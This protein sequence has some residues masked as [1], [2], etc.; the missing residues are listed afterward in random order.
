MAVNDIG[1][2]DQNSRQISCAPTGR[3]RDLGTES[4]AKLVPQTIMVYLIGT[5]LSGDASFLVACEGSQQL[6]AYETWKEA[7]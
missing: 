3:G 6:T 7:A 1:G 5:E 4:R 2:N